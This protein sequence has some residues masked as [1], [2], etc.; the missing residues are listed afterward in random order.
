MMRILAFTL[1]MLG[2]ANALPYS[3]TKADNKLTNRNLLQDLVIHW[4]SSN[5]ISSNT[6]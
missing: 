4:F 1:G 5:L 3:D 2:I 6:N